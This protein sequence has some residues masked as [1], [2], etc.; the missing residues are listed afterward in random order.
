MISRTAMTY[1]CAT[2]VDKENIAQWIVDYA[3]I[4]LLSLRLEG[5]ETL[6]FRYVCRP[7]C[8]KV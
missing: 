5:E 3:N 7:P 8:D 4:A 2:L 6:K 1:S